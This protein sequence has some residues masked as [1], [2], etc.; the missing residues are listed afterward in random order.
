MRY[1][2][3][4]KVKMAGYVHVAR[5]IDKCRAMLLGTLGEYI[6]P[7]PMDQRVL[8]FAEISAEQFTNAVRLSSDDEVE[9]WFR[10]TA[11]P[12]TSDEIEAF[13]RMMLTGGPTTEEKWVYLKKCRDAVDPS[14]RDIVS[15]ADLFDLEEKRAVPIGHVDM[16]EGT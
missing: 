16:V 11:R 12:H 8:E 3:S 6:Y 10:K 5:M 13:N 9:L 14:R 2:R 4:V 7:C 1:P 15:W